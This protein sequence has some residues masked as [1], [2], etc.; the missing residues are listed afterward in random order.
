MGIK[1]SIVVPVLNGEKTLPLCLDSLCALD[2]PKE[3]LEILVVDNNSTDN[4]KSIIEQ[5][6][7]RYLFEAKRNAGAARNRG[8]QEAQGEFAAFLDADCVADKRWLRNIIKGFTKDYIAGCGGRLLCYQP[9]TKIERFKQIRSAFLREGGYFSI[10]FLLPAI[11]TGNAIYR[12]KT[13][14]EAG[15]FDDSYTAR[16][17]DIDLAWRVCLKG[18]QLRYIPDAIVYHKCRNTFFGML[19]QNFLAGYSNILLYEK[20]K[21]LDKRLCYS[22]FAYWGKSRI[23]LSKNFL[24]IKI[25]DALGVLLGEIYARLALILNKEKITPL[26]PPVKKIFWRKRRDEIIVSCLGKKTDY[27]LNNIS[28]RI[29]EML[30]EGKSDSEIIDEIVD[31]YEIDREQAAQDLGSFMDELEKEELLSDGFS[32]NCNRRI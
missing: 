11:P 25:I 20:Y 30:M 15:I 13:L 12:R 29:W 32:Q 7:V 19:K 6:P 4:T 24:P 8:I 23:V 28:S 9:R 10:D 21:N 2:Y 18:Y 27:I 3:K 22:R 5:Y 16:N 14:I 31:I 17:E 1:V 26:E